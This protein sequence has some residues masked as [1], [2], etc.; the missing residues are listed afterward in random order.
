MAKHLAPSLPSPDEI[1]PLSTVD[2]NRL[3]HICQMILNVSIPPKTVVHVDICQHDE[4]AGEPAYIELDCRPP[5]DA[6]F[7]KKL[8]QAIIDA[9][10]IQGRT[11]TCHKGDRSLYKALYQA[12]EH[13]S[14]QKCM[15]DFCEVQKILKADHP[16]LFELARRSRAH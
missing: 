16:L 15:D 13:R 3:H 10:P 8:A 4:D 1:Q 7:E 5:L 9:F 6:D 12:P 14:A 11:G 2:R